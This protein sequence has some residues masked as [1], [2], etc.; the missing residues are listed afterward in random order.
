MCST[1]LAED[2]VLGPELLD[3]GTFDGN[4]DHWTLEEGWEYGDGNVTFEI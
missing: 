4:A 3:N 2:A 1:T